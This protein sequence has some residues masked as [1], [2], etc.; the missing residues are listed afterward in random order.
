MATSA[1]TSFRFC[2]PAGY[3][4]NQAGAGATGNINTDTES[5]PIDSAGPTYVQVA[6]LAY[7]AEKRNVQVQT[8][9]FH[10]DGLGGQNPNVYST[11]YIVVPKSAL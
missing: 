10:T 4:Y 5:Q 8:G 9:V 6:P 1:S 7:S 3:P 11:V 2:M